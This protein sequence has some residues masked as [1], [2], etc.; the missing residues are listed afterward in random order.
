MVQELGYSYIIIGIAYMLYNLISSGVTFVALKTS[1]GLKRVI[2]QSSI[3]IFALFLLS[4]SLGYF[5]VLFLILAI[6]EGLCMGFFESIIAKTTK[7]SKCISVD[8]GLLNIQMRLSEFFSIL[9]AGFIAESIGYTPIFVL[10]GIF[11]LI[12]SISSWYFLK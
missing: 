8:I 12:F 10:S 9:Y 6:A 5:L 11:F 2:L 4:N 3:A 1:L 7:E